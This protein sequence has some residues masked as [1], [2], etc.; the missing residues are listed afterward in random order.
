MRNVLLIGGNADG[1]WRKVTVDKTG[2]PVVAS[3]SVVEEPR[4]IERVRSMF[5]PY[6]H[7]PRDLS[8]TYYAVPLR[9]ADGWYYV[10]ATEEARDRVIER[11]LEGYSPEKKE[12]T[13]CDCSSN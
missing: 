9:S 10:F 12:E 2:R 1:Q 7:Q 4:V 3:I 8:V 11:L 5:L 6:S 13:A